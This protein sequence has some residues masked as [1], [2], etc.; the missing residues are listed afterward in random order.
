[1]DVG[2]I[3]S[4][5]KNYAPGLGGMTV[6]LLFV[7]GISASWVDL[8]VSEKTTSIEK[9]VAILQKDV[10]GLKTG[11]ETIKSEL[12]K[13]KADREEIIKLIKASTGK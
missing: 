7:T 1:M 8:F 6:V 5:L 4:F 10:G 3:K 2:G 13:A 11:Q 12:Q 9:D